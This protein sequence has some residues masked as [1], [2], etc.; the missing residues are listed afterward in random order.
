MSPHTYTNSPIIHAPYPSV[1][2]LVHYT[3]SITSMHTHLCFFLCI[4]SNRINSSFLLS[5]PSPSP[6][7]LP[8]LS[9]SIAVTGYKCITSYMPGV[10]DNGRRRDIYL[11]RCLRK[12]SSPNPIDHLYQLFP[13]G[14]QKCVL[15]D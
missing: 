10:I 6:Y 13:M 7:L 15:K 3:N 5:Y 8:L 11:T 4:L 14:L 9:C 12:V 1:S 2:V